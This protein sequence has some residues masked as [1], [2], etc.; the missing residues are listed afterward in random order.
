LLLPVVVE[1]PVVGLVEL[2]VLRVAQPVLLEVMVKVL[3]VLVE[4]R[5][6]VEQVVFHLEQQLP[7]ELLEPLD[8]VVLVDQQQHLVQLLPVVEAVEADTSVVAVEELTP[9]Q[10]ELMV[11]VAVVV[12]VM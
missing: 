3:G 5:L 10:L 1:E 9:I 11:V 6:L 4:L 7:T 2:V 12:L 8:K